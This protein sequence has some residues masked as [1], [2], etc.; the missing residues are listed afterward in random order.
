MR[1]RLLMIAMSGLV[2]CCANSSVMAE[3]WGHWRGANGNGLAVSAKPP[4]QFGAT[5]NVK[6]KVEIPGRSSGS[7]VIWNNQVFV[8]TA[9]PTGAPRG[10]LA[11]KLLC[12]DRATGKPLWAKTA[13]ETSPHAPTHETNGYASASPCTDGEFVYAHFG[14]QGLY[15]YTMKGELV[16]NRDFGDMSIRNNF[17]EGSSPTIAGD[18]L[19]V[20]WDHESSSKLFALDKRTGKNIWEVSRNEPTC[21]ATP[22]IA[23]DATG[24]SQIVMNGQTAARGYDLKTGKELWYCS[25]QTERPC[26]SA[27]SQ[28]GIAFV[29]SGFRGAF[30]GAFDMTG[31]GNLAGTK[32]VLW[33][34]KQDTPDVASPLLSNGRLYFYKG[35]TGQLTCVDAKTGKVHYAASRIDGMRS[36]YASPVAAGGYVFLTDRDGTIVVIE[37]S[38]Q[39]KIVATNRFGEG[40]DATPAI[41]D[42]EMFIRSEGHLFCIA[43]K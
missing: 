22:L 7:P 8:V 26:A 10:P 16:W 20:P 17:G 19:I 24:R 42:G 21:W 23:K 39:L 30:M 11:F 41:V 2:Y 6:W 27:V 9:A 32:K 40:I 4:T 33:S 38:D 28:D 3:N 13:V 5:E 18:M 37:D 31:E 14:S 34:M 1:A 12:L 43:Q 25:G 35:K 36:T 15:C 29:G